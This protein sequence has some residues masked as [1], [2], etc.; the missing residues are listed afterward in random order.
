M[1]VIDDLLVRPFLSLLDIIHSLALHE[2]YDTEE[3]RNE[4]KENALLHDLGE[5]D[6]DEYERRKAE[7]E[8]QL[9]FAE[10][11]HDQLRNDRI[12]VKQ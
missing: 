4:L 12:E 9:A 6:T 10:R 5:R 2:A 11:L 1:L 3:I 8:E 7:L